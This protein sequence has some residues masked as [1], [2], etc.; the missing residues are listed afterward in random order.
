VS[1]PVQIGLDVEML[2][3]KADVIDRSRAQARPKYYR[4]SC[5]LVR[6]MPS[7]AAP[8]ATPNAKPSPT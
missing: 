8:N 6:H 5:D 7:I 2:E 1:P 4:R 3:A